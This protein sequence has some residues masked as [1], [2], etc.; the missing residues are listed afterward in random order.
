MSGEL[1]GK[2]ALVTGANSGIG[3]AIAETYAAAGATVAVHGRSENRIAET[4][5]AIEKAGGQAVPVIADMSDRDQ[6]K[7]MCADTL[8][9]LGGIDIVMNNAG[10]CSLAPLVD[11]EEAM[12]DTTLDVNLTACFIVTKALLPR[13]IEQGAG[14]RLLYI[15]SVSGKEAETNSC[16]YNASKAGLIL[17]AKC[18]AR[19]VGPNGVTVNSICP[20]WIDTKMAVELHKDLATEQ[21]RDYGEVFEESMGSNMMGIIQGPQDI[22]DCALF[23]AGDGGKHITGQAINVCAGISTV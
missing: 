8:E 10:F 17:F 12:W 23:L 9:K 18:L 21:K 20:G 7:A 3:R 19:E 22:A 4:M 13:M 11:T 6:V 5:T 15:S 14:G 2:R 1:A 16:A